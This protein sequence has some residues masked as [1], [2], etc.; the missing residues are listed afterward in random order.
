MSPN[1]KTVKAYTGMPSP[2]PITPGSWIALTD[3][4]E[5]VSQTAASSSTSRRHGG[6]IDR[7]RC[8]DALTLVRSGSP[9]F[10]LVGVGRE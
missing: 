5:W 9:A 2:C 3:D 1:K 6:P 10:L 7:R 8:V 4:V